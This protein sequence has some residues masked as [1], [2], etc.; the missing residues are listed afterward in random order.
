MQTATDNRIWLLVILCCVYSYL[1]KKDNHWLYFQRA[2]RSIIC[3]FGHMWNHY[4]A[5]L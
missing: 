2:L 4:E 1:F 3:K 5:L